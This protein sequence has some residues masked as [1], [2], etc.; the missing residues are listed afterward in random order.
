M[1]RRK[2]RRVRKRRRRRSEKKARGIFF[3]FRYL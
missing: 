3:S 1:R 2:W